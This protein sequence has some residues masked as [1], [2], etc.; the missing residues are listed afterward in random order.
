MKIST[1]GRYSL[2]LMLDIAIHGADKNVSIR[3]AAKRQNISMKYLEQIVSMLVRVGYLKSIRG[4]QGGYRLAKS[5]AE[6]TVGDILRITEG[7]LAPVSCLEDEVNQCPR[8]EQCPMI[9]MWTGLYETINNYVDGITLEDL[10]NENLKENN[11]F[12]FCI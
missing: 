3:D 11:V 7:S 10:M 1:K 5:P 8:V 2:R 12:D 6:Y 4:A 9:E